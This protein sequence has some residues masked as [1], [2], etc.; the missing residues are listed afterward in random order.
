MP[1]LI[2]VRP[3]EGGGLEIC[4]K[5]EGRELVT[6]RLAR[7]QVW[8]LHNETGVYLAMVYAQEDRQ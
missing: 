1:D 5:P 4:I 6:A 3:A 2:Y 7:R 8:R